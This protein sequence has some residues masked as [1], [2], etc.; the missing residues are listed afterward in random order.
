MTGELRH[1]SRRGD[2]GYHPGTYELGGERQEYE[3]EELAHVAHLVQMRE[4]DE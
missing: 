1:S 4:E 2:K 3:F